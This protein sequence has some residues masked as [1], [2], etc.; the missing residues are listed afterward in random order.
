MRGSAPS[1]S[2]FQLPKLVNIKW[3][4]SI[5]RFEPS[6]ITHDG[7]EP[8]GLLQLK[9]PFDIYYATIGAKAAATMATTQEYATL[10]LALWE[11]QLTC[12]STRP[13]EEAGVKAESPDQ[14]RPETE[15]LKRKVDLDH[16]STDGGSPKRARHERTGN[17]R[18]G[19][20][21]SPYSLKRRP[22]MDNRRP[23]IENRR[24]SYDEPA[25]RPS[26]TAEDKK[27]GKRL[28]GGL[29][30]TLSQTNTNSQQKR[31]QEIEKR[32]Y[33]RIQKQKA[34]DDQKREDKLARLNYIRMAE[35]MDFERKVV[36]FSP[37]H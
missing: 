21:P 37:T 36:S 4:A 27:R 9:L 34:E 6:D 1:N 5:S 3:A 32:Q 2:R 10:Q 24:L 13:F 11:T 7:S 18:R 20:S 16:D 33:E 31:R 35:Q 26:A 29:L 25:R 15:K 30:S 22:S 28:F 12:P 14:N 8:T 23:S 19:R 17:D